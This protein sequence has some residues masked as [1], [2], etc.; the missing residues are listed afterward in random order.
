MNPGLFYDIMK[1]ILVFV[2]RILY[3]YEV[4]GLENIPKDGKV[5]VCPN[6]ISNLD[7]LVLIAAQKRKINFMGKS[8]LFKNKFLAKVFSAMGV[9][10]VNRGKGDTKAID[11]AIKILDEDLVLGIFIE[12]TRS[13]TGELLKPKSGV[14]LIA[15]KTGAPVL[16]VCITTKSGKPVKLFR[17]VIVSYSKPLSVEELGLKDGGAKE[18]RNSS[19]IIM[20]KI[21]QMKQYYT[22]ID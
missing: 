3:P 4:H 21:R 7:P 6:H 13:K 14:S 17:K 18:F 15:H 19:R 9:F 10:P 8:E 22:N 11:T 16:P 1:Y 20:D 2:L 12:G 5:I